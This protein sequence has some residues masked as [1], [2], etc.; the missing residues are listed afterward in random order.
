VRIREQR[1]R[2]QLD[3][4]QTLRVGRAR[5]D[6]VH[7]RAFGRRGLELAAEP[8]GR[9]PLVVKRIRGDRCAVGAEQVHQS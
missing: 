1:R 6:P 8:V 3:V 4:T 9:D 2:D 7:V 5:R